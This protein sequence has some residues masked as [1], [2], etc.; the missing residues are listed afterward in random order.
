MF[1]NLRLR[2]LRW[3]RGLVFQSFC[4][5]IVKEDEAGAELFRDLY[6]KVQARVEEL[7]AKL[8]QK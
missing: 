8:V 3:Y 5:A 6:K 7:E 2:V 1:L 4:M